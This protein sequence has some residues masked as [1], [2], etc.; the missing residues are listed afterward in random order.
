MAENLEADYGAMYDISRHAMHS[1][2]MLAVATETTTNMIEEHKAFFQENASLSKAAIT[3]SK[4][5][6]RTLQF[7]KTIFKGLYLRSKD[8]KERV[9]NESKL[10]ELVIA[11]YAMS[12]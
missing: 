4:A 6:R 10:V 8:L 1:S 3:L 7:Q 2:E 12:C 5:S 11:S 9:E